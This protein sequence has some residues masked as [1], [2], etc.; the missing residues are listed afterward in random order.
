MMYKT[1][2]IAYFLTFISHILWRQCDVFYDL[3]C[4]RDSLEDVFQLRA[5]FDNWL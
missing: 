5:Q 1:Y 2:D 4:R 3:P